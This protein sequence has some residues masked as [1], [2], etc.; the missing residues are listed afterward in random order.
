LAIVCFPK[1]LALVECVLWCFA[2]LAIG[3]VW[4]HGRGVFDVLFNSTWYTKISTGSYI[5]MYIGK[6]VCWSNTPCAF[7]RVSQIHNCDVDAYDEIDVDNAGNK[8]KV[9]QIAAFTIILSRIGCVF[10]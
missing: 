5:Y 3:V 2:D 1:I 8:R 6:W 7:V 10:Q 9:A 4:V